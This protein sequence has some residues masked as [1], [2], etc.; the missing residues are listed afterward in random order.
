MAAESTARCTDCPRECG[1]DRSGG[2]EGFCRTGPDLN[3]ASV[4]LHRGEEPAISGPAGICNIFFSG[5]NLRCRYCQN[6]QISRGPRRTGLEMEEV[7]R[8]VKAAL[9]AGASHLGLVSPSHCI[10]RMKSIVDTLRAA[11]LRP[12]TVMNTNSYDKVETLKSLAGIIDVY[13]PDLKYLDG[14]PAE[15][16][17]GARDYPEAAGRALREMFRQKGAEVELTDS[18]LIASG[19]I[20]RHLVLPGLVEN[21]KACLRFIAEELSPAVHISLMAQYHP[22]PEVSGD[23]DLGR[24][25]REEE[26]EEVRQEMERLGFFR[27]WTQELSSE[28]HYLPDFTRRRPFG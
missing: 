27:G 4:C 1:V 6:H 23:P 22:T 10:S 20:I 25:L 5:C 13:L 28:D 16:Y 18:G 12:V 15:R 7:V 17:S 2:E 9:A 8:E 11:G 19:L 3:V 14:E 21:S 26:Y 24:T